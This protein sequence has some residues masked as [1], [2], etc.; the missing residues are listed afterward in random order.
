M[1][2]ETKDAKASTQR[3]IDELQSE[4]DARNTYLNAFKTEMAKTKYAQWSERQDK[5]N[6]AYDR[7]FAQYDHRFQPGD[8]YEHRVVQKRPRT[9][10]N[11]KEEFRNIVTSSQSVGWR[12]KYDHWRFNHERRG[13]MKHT[14]W[15]RGHL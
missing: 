15:D 4:I 5:E 2:R 6:Y 11:A 10:F 12:S 9:T 1:Q 7:V 3:K 13:T 14:F 8:K